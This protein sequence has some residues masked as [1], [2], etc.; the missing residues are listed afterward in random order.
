MKKSERAI[1]TSHPSALAH[2]QSRALPAAIFPPPPRQGACAQRQPRA[3]QLLKAMRAVLWNTRSALLYSVGC[4]TVLG[5]MLHYSRTSSGGAES[6][7]EH[8]NETNEDL[9]RKVV[10]A[11]TPIGLRITSVTT[12][13]KELPPLTRLLRRISTFFTPSSSPP[14]SES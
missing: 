10:V 14:P 12:Y 1:F 2:A 8:E 13:H 11:D 9:S 4:W 6:G 3:R 5:G 7:G